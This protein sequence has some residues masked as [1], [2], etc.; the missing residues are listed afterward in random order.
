MA[1]YTVR[2]EQDEGGWWVASIKE[3]KGVH[4]Q[5]RSIEAARKRVREALATAVD[6]ADTAELVDDIKLPATF[7]RE[8]AT[9]RRAQ[10]QA[11][12]EQEHASKLA[13]K[14]ARE[15]AAKMSV[16]DAAAVMGLSHQ[17]VQQLVGG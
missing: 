15:L 4:T 13:I 2:Y 12:R 14:I 8:L 1:T 11:K 5:G 16:R 10:L 7:K 3:V 6:D 17:R 9:L